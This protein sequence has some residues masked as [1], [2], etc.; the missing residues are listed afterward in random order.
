MRRYFFNIRSGCDYARDDHGEVCLSLAVAAARATAGARQLLQ[1]LHSSRRDAQ[2]TAFE[3]TDVRGRLCLRV[4]VTTTRKATRHEKA[5]IPVLDRGLGMP[6]RH[7]QEPKEHI[8]S[9]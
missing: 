1:E 7:Q 3:I 8:W 9:H 4:P 2:M 6:R 5:P